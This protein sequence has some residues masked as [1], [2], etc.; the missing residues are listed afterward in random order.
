[1]KIS[2]LKVSH[3]QK[4]NYY[5]T[6]DHEVRVIEG[7]RQNSSKVI[8]DIYDQNFIKIKKMVLTFKNTMLDPEDIFQEG[9][10]RAIINIQGGKFNQESSFSTYLNG[11]CR[12]VCLKQ[13]SKK[14]TSELN[15]NFD[16][17]TEE[18]Q[19]FDGLNALLNIKEQLDARCKEIIDLRFTLSDSISLNDPNRCM[20]FCEI[21]ER[22]QMTTANARQRFKR[23]MDNLR[24]L[25][26][27][28]P[29][30]TDYFI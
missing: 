16:P 4:G 3:K 13:L 6:D 18:E 17:V 2:T 30:L 24:K 28:S 25:A 26:N 29:E 14:Q 22:M 9:L 20:P 5:L 11:I 19:N 8:S 21:A 12:N 15:E 10:T 1:M 7:I 27:K 23:C